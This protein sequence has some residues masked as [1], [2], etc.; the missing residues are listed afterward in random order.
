MRTLFATLAA[1]ILLA[2]LTAAA[3]AQTP[4]ATSPTVV[5]LFTS[6]SCSSCPPAEAYF[7]ELAKR[8]DLISL[9]WH[10]DYWDTLRDGENGRWK[11]PY[12]SAANTARQ[13]AY[14]QTI[15]GR[16]GVYTPQAIVAGSTAAVGSDRRAVQ[17]LIDAAQH[18]PASVRVVIAPQTDASATLYATVEDAPK[19]AAIELVT[20]RREAVTSVKGGENRGRTLMSANIVTGVQIIGTTGLKFQTPADG[21]GCAVLVRDGHTGRILG[22][23][24][25]PLT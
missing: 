7:A 8:P 19:D 23:A 2:G 14:N 5:E 3:S 25:C 9:E 11:D 1:A 4:R 13:R 18:T 16:S 24:T 21:D 22:A 6:Q 20:F 17:A 12:S 15:R 10:V